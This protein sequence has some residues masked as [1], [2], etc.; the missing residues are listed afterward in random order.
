M[1][2]NSGRNEKGNT[3][4]ECHLVLDCPCT[5]LQRNAKA[6]TVPCI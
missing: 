3:K 2:E 5:E 4:T 1:T 6:N